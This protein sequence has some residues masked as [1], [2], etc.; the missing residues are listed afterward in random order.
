MTES[1]SPSPDHSPLGSHSLELVYF[2]KLSTYYH[3]QRNFLTKLK[4]CESLAK[5]YFRPTWVYTSRASRQSQDSTV[6][7]N[8]KDCS[9]YELKNIKNIK[10]IKKHCFKIVH[11]PPKHY[12]SPYLLI[13]PGNQK[14]TLFPRGPF[15]QR[16]INNLNV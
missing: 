12:P 5:S 4:N 11:L 7:E 1:G 10:N 2:C 9:R 3:P 8:M 14:K 6:S 16:E 15:P 13:I